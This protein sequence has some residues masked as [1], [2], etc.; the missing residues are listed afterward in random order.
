MKF[1]YLC[2]TKD[3]GRHFINIKSNGEHNIISILF[4]A[5]KSISPLDEM[6]TPFEERFNDEW[7]L[8]VQSTVGQFKVKI[9]LPYDD[10]WITSSTETITAIY[11]LLE[12]DER[13]ERIGRQMNRM[14]YFIGF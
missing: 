2:I 12:K 7:E 5:L 4:D 14:F 10:V 13:F 8:G 9:E 11:L 1:R 3:S 6:L